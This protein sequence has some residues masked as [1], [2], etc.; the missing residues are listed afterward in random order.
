[1]S[2]IFFM[3]IFLSIYFVILFSSP[4]FT[5]AFS[6]LLSVKYFC[7]FHYLLKYFCMITLNIFL[8]VILFFFAMN[9]ILHSIFFLS[10]FFQFLEFFRFFQCYSYFYFNQYQLFSLFFPSF[11]PLFSLTYFNDLL[12]LCCESNLL[13]IN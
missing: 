1:M 6:Q 2:S 9:S 5:L 8:K 4:H 10:F 13:L 7:F 12:S 3:L 11:T